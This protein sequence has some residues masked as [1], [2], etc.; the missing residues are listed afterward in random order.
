[1]LSKTHIRLIYYV[2]P[3]I[4]SILFVLDYTHAE[5]H[6][7]YP[8]CC[9]KEISKF[10][11]YCDEIFIIVAHK[12]GFEVNED[13]PKPTILLDN[14]I[15]LQQF[16]TYLGWDAKEILPFY[17]HKKN[18]LVIPCYCKLDNLAHEFVHYF[19]SAYQNEDLD[20]SDGM[21]AEEREIE[22]TLIQRWFKSNYMKT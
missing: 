12:M 17:F 13:I 21:L 14:Q 19:Q 5:Q 2:V 16:N 6:K 10:R 8:S 3:I 20:C 7:S 1:M 15:T 4:L 11:V 9:I 22:A 18:I